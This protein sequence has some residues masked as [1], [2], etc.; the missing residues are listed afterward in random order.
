[1]N[2]NELK[3]LL[4]NNFCRDIAVKEY[5]NGAI[6]SLP[7]QDHDGDG[8][9]IYL[10]PTD[11]GWS[12]SDG[13]STIMRLSYEH[14]VEALL[15]GSKL[16]L[17]N[18]YVKA[19]GAEYDDGELNM[20][21]PADALMSGIF[22]FTQLMNR[23]SDISLLKTYRAVSTFKDELRE[24]L[25]GILSKDIIHENFIVPNVPNAENYTIDYKI[26]SHTPLYLFA[27]NTKDSARLAIIT[28][29]H[30]E[31]Y[32]SN[33]NSLVVLEDISKISQQDLERLMNASDV[34]P[35]IHELDSMKRKINHKLSYS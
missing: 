18:Y 29:Q 14:D 32:G 13:A 6:L 23:V 19:A 27:A 17:F 26:D 16:D 1:M 31:K 10:T 5:R 7:I 4:C 11:G 22:N 25:Y 28:I 21:I 8:F 20:S 24:A 30:I 2:F 33:F 12:L 9:S 34:L 35:N 3:Q 15:K